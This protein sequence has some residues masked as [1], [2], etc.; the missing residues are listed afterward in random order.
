MFCVIDCAKL[1][2]SDPLLIATPP[3][4]TLTT[5]HH[6]FSFGTIFQD[7]FGTNNSGQFSPTTY[8]VL[9]ET[10]HHVA[11]HVIRDFTELNA[12]ETHDQISAPTFFAH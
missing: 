1:V 8:G 7:V 5:I 6:K 9:A 11:F 3:K 10:G 2:S 12:F 4:F